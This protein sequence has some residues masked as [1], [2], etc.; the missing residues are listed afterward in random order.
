MKYLT[1]RGES[2]CPWASKCVTY[3]EAPFNLV[4]SIR[5]AKSTF[6]FPRT[7]GFTSGSQV[8][9]TLYILEKKDA[10]LA[11]AMKEAKHKDV[12]YKLYH[13]N[14]LH[15]FLHDDAMREQRKVISL[16]GLFAEEM[17]K[18]TSL[19]LQIWKQALHLKILDQNEF[20]ALGEMKQKL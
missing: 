1:T 12:R 8:I 9:S 20:F 15:K 17:K 2:L 4:R 3:E 19:D 11:L 16:Q 7:K 10:K 18:V 13:S 6:R 5:N 14:M